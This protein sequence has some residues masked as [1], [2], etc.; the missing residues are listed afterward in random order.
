MNALEINDLF[1]RE[2]PAGRLYVKLR[3]MDI[4]VEREWMMSEAGV[5]YVVDLAL[6]VEGGWLPVIFGDQPGPTSGLRFT[7]HVEPDTCL[8][9]IRGRLGDA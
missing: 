3:E 4:P 8:R 9:E 5:E 6:P 1:E 2:S 7:A